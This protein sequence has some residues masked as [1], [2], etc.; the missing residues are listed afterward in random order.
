M[1]HSINLLPWREQRRTRHKHRFVLLILLGILLAIA[2]Q[3]LIAANVESQI[4]AQAQRL[5]A[6]KTQ[7]THE[8]LQL[9]Q[10]QQTQQALRLLQQRIS[11]LELLRRK[12]HAVADFAEA[13]PTYI[14]QGVYLDKL[15]LVGEQVNLVGI[16][17][18]TSYI[19]ILMDKLKASPQFHHIN[20]HSIVHDRERFGRHYL[21]FRVSFSIDSHIDLKRE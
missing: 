3:G 21:T 8:Q 20:V 4:Q 16:S 14:P 2:T 15:H 5:D 13:I 6:L 12:S 18:D 1:L 11:E 17:D 19:T 10:L 7:W 9:E